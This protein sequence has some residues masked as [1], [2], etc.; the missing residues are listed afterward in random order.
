M[1]SVDDSVMDRRK[2]IVDFLDNG[3]TAI[4][5]VLAA[6]NFEWT[7]RRTIIDLGQSPTAHF[8]AEKGIFYECHG[9]DGYKNVWQAEVYPLVKTRLPGVVP[10]W[11]YFKK[12]AFPL[13]H[14]LMHG[15]KGSTGK[16]FGSDRVV[17]MLDASEALIQFASTNRVNIFERIKVRRK[18]RNLSDLDDSL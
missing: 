14:K 3:E 18:K 2:K 9:L 17:A 16:G 8:K 1:F 15:A 13:R 7:I 6:A 4:A 12:Q 10:N 11:E 5:V